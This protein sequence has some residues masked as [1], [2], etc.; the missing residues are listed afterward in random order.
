MKVQ[1][2]ELPG[3]GKKFVLN[4]RSGDKMVIIVHDDGRREFYHF[5]YDDPDESISN[6]TLDDDE[7]RQLAAIAGGMMY[8]PKALETID[9]VLDGLLVEWYKIEPQSAVVGKTIGEL[10]VRQ[11]TGATV[12][13][14]IEKNHTKH[15]NPGPDYVI[16]AESTIIVLGEREHQKQIRKILTVDGSV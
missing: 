7:A 8:S 15:I 9:V 1:E 4:A 10:D 12:I 2:S 6:V 13:A 5:D 16:T 14:A 11:T 3:I